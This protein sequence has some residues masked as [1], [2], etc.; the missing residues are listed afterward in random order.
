MWYVVSY[1]QDMETGEVKPVGVVAGPFEKQED[2]YQVARANESKYYWGDDWNYQCEARRA[3][4]ENELTEAYSH[5][6]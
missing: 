5:N 4:S 6:S 3:A 2:A 1:L